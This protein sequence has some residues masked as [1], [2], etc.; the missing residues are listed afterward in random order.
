MSLDHDI[1]VLARVSLFSGLELEQLRLLAFGC[2]R[3][4]APGGST[5]VS[6]GEPAD[7]AL[8]VLSGAVELTPGA[9]RPGQTQVGGPAT[10]IAMP[11]LF[12]E[13][14]H[15]FSAAARTPCVLLHLRRQVFLRLLE[16]YPALA[17]GLHRQLAQRIS[18]FTAEVGDLGAALD[19][20]TPGPAPRNEGRG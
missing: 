16:E 8:V 11:A 10:L 13:V 6:A 15:T 1:R 5:I 14:D 2:E 19:A 20:T 17:I 9:G 12:S 3:R 7:G 4:T 18:A